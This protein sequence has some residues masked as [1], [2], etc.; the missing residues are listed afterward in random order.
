M[1]GERG[2]VRSGR[3]EIKRGNYVSLAEFQNDPDPQ[4]RKASLNTLEKAP[5]RHERDQGSRA[6]ATYQRRLK[7]IDRGFYN[8]QPALGRLSVHF[9]LLER[10]QNVQ[11]FHYAAESGILRVQMR[12]RT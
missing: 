2:A 5:A 9:F 7:R 11:A 1:K 10:V 3:V 8:F 4:N 12:R 6:D